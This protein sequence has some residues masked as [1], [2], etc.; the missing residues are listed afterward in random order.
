[1]IGNPQP[2]YAG[3]RQTQGQPRLITGRVSSSKLTCLS[4][5][6]LYRN[7]FLLTLQ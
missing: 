7:P 2:S 1:M 6:R 5:V 4:N 3:N